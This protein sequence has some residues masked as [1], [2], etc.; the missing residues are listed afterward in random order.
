MKTCTRDPYVAEDP[1]NDYI[2]VGSEV[3]TAAVMGYTAI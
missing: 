2:A 3:L 1:V